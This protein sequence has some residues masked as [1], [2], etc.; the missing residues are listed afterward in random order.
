MKRCDVRPALR[1]GVPDF[2]E[3]LVDQFTIVQS[4]IED[5]LRS[6]GV[7]QAWLNERAAEY[8]AQKIPAR[9]AGRIADEELAEL[10]NWLEKHWNATPRDTAAIMKFLKYLPGGDKLTQWSEAA[11]YLLAAVVATHHAFFGPIDL[12]VIGGFSLATWLTEKLSNQV[13]SRTR[14]ANVAIAQRFTALAHRQLE[15]MC[16]WLDRQAPSRI[17]LNELESL[18]GEIGAFADQALEAG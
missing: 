6:S 5:V 2:R 18:T 16:H 8:Q 15:Q 14:A 1:D 10:R 7:A 17:A 3:A 9:D 11:P 12:L 4:R 13:A